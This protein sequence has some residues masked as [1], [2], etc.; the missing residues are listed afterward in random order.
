MSRQRPPATT[1]MVGPAHWHAGAVWGIATAAVFIACAYA[2]AQGWAFGTAVVLTALIFSIFFSWKATKNSTKG[3]LSWDGE[4]WHLSGADGIA[5][6]QVHCVLDLQRC[7]LLHGNGESGAPLWMWL[8]SPSMSPQWLSFRRAI[9]S[10][11]V[12]GMGNGVN[13]LH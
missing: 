11:D 3:N 4:V 10:P 1:W 9:V 6:V 7:M 13:I 12:D 8:E 2:M 5:P